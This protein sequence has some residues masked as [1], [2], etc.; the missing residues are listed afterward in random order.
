MYGHVLHC[1]TIPPVIN[2][3]AVQQ[4]QQYNDDD[5]NKN[6]KF[7]HKAQGHASTVTGQQQAP[8]LLLHTVT[9][10]LP[11]VTHTRWGGRKTC[12]KESGDEGY[13]NCLCHLH[14]DD[15]RITCLQEMS[16]TVCLDNQ[17]ATA[18]SFTL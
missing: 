15:N 8:H 13:P 5:N 4:Q 6:N 1:T 17:A 11:T 16:C 10:S 14:C 18:N 12:S 2:P 3:Q 7:P 9:H